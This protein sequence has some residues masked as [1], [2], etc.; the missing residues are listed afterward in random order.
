MVKESHDLLI[1]H[2]QKIQQLEF[3]CA[4]IKEQN[5]GF[6]LLFKTSATLPNNDFDVKPKAKEDGTTN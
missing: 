6:E 1:V 4:E 2:E 3:S 5:K